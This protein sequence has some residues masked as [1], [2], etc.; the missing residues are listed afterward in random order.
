MLLIYNS[1]ID[2]LLVQKLMNPIFALGTCVRLLFY[3]GRKWNY[4][5]FTGL[6][7]YNVFL[8]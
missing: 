4:I 1:L 8:I 6:S 3:F 5:V 7:I 2:K